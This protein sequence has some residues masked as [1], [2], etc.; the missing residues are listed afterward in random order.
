MKASLSLSLGLRPAA[1]AAAVI[2]LASST[3][4][5]PSASPARPPSGRWQDASLD[6]YRNHLVTLESLTQACAGARDLKTCDPTLVGLDDR[7]PLST[8]PGAERRIIRY[9][10]LR[11]LFSRAE[12]SDEPQPTPKLPLPV[13][14]PK[15]SIRPDA[16]SVSQL[17]QDAKA[18]L[19]SDLAHIPAQSNGEAPTH[20]TE[21]ST[22]Q[23][24]FAGREFRDLHKAGA[25]DSAFEMLGNWLNRF[26][27]NVARL[28][29]RSAW[30]GRLL[31]SGFLLAV[32]IGLAWGL[33]Q[34][35]RRWRV[36]MVPESE[37]PAP[38]AVSARDWQLWLADARMAAAQGLWREAIHCLYWSAISRLES[39]RLWPA[40]RARTPREYLAL[41]APDDPRLAR[42]QSLTLTFERIWYGGRQARENEYRNA[43]ELAAALTTRREAAAGEGG[44]R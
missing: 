36:R 6:D 22:M 35:E 23:Q 27:E 4:A 19:S 29:A 43:E 10:W 12:E 17:L 16:R 5:D 31:I 28:R 41:M 26:F 37:A 30:V 3:H 15:E 13:P 44:S 8:E 38:G 34:L 14:T 40:D 39:G 7:V 11:V 42:L 18:R 24:V 2:F 1:L 20:A 9:G 33:L 25:S 32:G 21:R